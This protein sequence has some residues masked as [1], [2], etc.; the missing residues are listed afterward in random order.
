MRRLLILHAAE[1]TDQTKECVEGFKTSSRNVPYDF[2][3][4]T[5]ESDVV[6]ATFQAVGD[7]EEHSTSNDMI[8]LRECAIVM[9]QRT[10]GNT[11]C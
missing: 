2:R 3:V 9:S 8:G 5:S 10:V 6:V 7:V 4:C 1:D 11:G